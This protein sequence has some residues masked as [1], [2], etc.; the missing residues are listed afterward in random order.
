MKFIFDSDSFKGTLTSE[1]IAVLLERAAK[2]VFEDCETVSVNLADG[3]EGTLD[4]LLG[5][6]GGEKIEVAVHNPLMEAIRAHY[7]MTRDHKAIIEMA[8]ASGLTLLSE[9]RRN[10]FYTS[11]YGTGELVKA[12]LEHGVN[13]IVIAIGGSATNDGGMGFASAL[14]VRFFDKSG[15]VLE[16]KGANLEKVAH[17][18]VSEILP[19]LKNVKFT[20]MCDVTNPLCGANGATY[21]YAVQKGASEEELPELEKGMQNYRD[22]IIK[23]FGVNPDQ[24]IGSGAAGG[25]GAALRIFFHANM[26]SGIETILDLTGFDGLIDG[27]DYIITGEGRADSQSACGKVLSGVGKR[28]LEKNIPVIALCGSLG[29]GFE[30]LKECGITSCISVSEGISVRDSM[31]NPSKYY[32]RKAVEVFGEIK[33]N[34]SDEF[35]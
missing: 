6:L 35:Y 32:Y 5:R 14:G 9:S 8:Q 18:D 25:M 34:L 19:N 27:A 11:S 31:K 30:K 28:G 22:V 2:S 33:E 24:I 13:E 3:G 17:I 16:G 7:G 15:Q 10:P 4:A 12:A 29:D 20:V 23:K 1:E 26:K 21:T